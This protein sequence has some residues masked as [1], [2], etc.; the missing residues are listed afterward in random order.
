M[1]CVIMCLCILFFNTVMSMGTVIQLAYN[2]KTHNQR[3][4]KHRHNGE[5]SGVLT[6]LGS[7]TVDALKHLS[8]MC[9]NDKK[10]KTRHSVTFMGSTKSE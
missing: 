5:D 8:C 1:K 7:A 9:Y 2:A 3:A 4:V 10:R 6:E